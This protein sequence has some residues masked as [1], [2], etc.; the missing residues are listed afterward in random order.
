[1]ASKEA[2]KTPSKCSLSK[3]IISPQTSVVKKQ[4]S[5]MEFCELLL[6]LND[7]IKKLTDKVSLLN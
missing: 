2:T 4:F 3:T 7:N 1:M 6:K 5:E